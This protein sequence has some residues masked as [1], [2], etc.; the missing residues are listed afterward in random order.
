MTSFGPDFTDRPISIETSTATV[1]G[2]IRFLGQ[3]L[4]YENEQDRSTIE[5]DPATAA[6]AHK[7]LSPPDIPHLTD[8]LQDDLFNDVGKV[9]VRDVYNSLAGSV[10]MLGISS[11]FVK[12]GSGKA[13]WY[14]FI[15]DD[16]DISVLCKDGMQQVNDDRDKRRINKR[17]KPFQ[18]AM[19]Y[20]SGVEPS[21]F[22]RHK[23]GI[24][25]VAALALTVGGSAIYMRVRHKSHNS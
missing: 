1:P 10:A 16:Q 11:H 19:D 22:S 25:G 21:S 15:I 5:L 4:L 7:L 6:F 13:S 18:H 17:V 24:V 3:T 23:K 2:V 8:Q 14:G 12:L 20:Y 9:N